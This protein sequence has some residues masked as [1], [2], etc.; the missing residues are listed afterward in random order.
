MKEFFRA[1][2]PRD[3][4]LYWLLVSIYRNPCL[5]VIA[6]FRSI[7]ATRKLTGRLFPVKVC[8][9]AG[10]RLNIF[11]SSKARVQIFGMLKVNPYIGYNAESS[12]HLRDESSFVVYGNFEIGPGVHI[13]LNRNAVLRIKGQVA[14]TASGI[15]CDSRIMV[16]NSIEIGSD[17]IIAWDVSITDSDWHEIIDVPRNSPVVIGDNVWISHGVSII[18]GANIPSG[19]IV[20]AKS[21]VGRGEF[22]NNALIA[23]VPARVKKVGVEWTR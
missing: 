1:H 18:K 14:S 21:L 16:E 12:I 6:F 15:T 2:V 19:C 10:Q 7:N 5:F 23:G 8:L 4:F 11:R 9:G 17:C 22:L 20:G 13:F 3:S